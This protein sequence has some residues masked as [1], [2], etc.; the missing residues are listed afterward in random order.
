M[1]FAEL[2][3]VDSRNILKLL[4]DQYHL[5]FN[6]YAMISLR[7]RIENS[8]QLHSMRFPDML[9]TRL[10][11]D[12]SFLDV[13]LHEISVESTE[14]FRDPSLWRLLRDEFFPR[15]IR[16]GLPFTIWIP[17]CVSGD[18]LYTLCIVLSE[19]NL[20]ANV[21]IIA[22]YLSETSLP[23]IH[24]GS[25]KPAKLEVSAENYKRYQGKNNFQDYFTGEAPLVSKKAD[26]LASVK[27]VKRSLNF[28]NA[29]KGV[30]MVIFRNQLVYYNQSL[31][32]RIT[33]LIW[34]TL[35]PG[36]HLLVGV[37]EQVQSPGEL[38]TFRLVNENESIYQKR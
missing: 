12:P 8:I 23:Q 21:T 1:E 11:E 17:S 24:T 31:S 14:L 33:G 32:D 18:E 4:N 19:C 15:L 3:I 6:D 29:P 25:I 20:K 30:D 16:P 7:R 26:L 2:G 9:I 34:D 38:K 28:E 35:T 37:K 22:G 5:D 10:K 13:F 27:F 36:G